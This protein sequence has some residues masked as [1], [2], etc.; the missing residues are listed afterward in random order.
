MHAF[1]FIDLKYSIIDR[2]MIFTAF[3]KCRPSGDTR[4]AVF[5][6]TG[7]INQALNGGGT[8]IG[9]ILGDMIGAPNMRDVISEMP[10]EQKQFICTMCRE[11]ISHEE[12]GKRNGDDGFHL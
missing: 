10:E 7:I 1:A 5:S 4:E 2:R 12:G 8:M 9:A 6:Y 3:H 11:N